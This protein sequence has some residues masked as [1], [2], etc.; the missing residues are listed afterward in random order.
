MKKPLLVP[1]TGRGFFSSR[2]L[3]GSRDWSPDLIPSYGLTERMVKT[4]P[5]NGDVEDTG[6]SQPSH[7]F[8]V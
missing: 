2:A 7:G 1:K 8:P 5:A 3:P 6:S 4:L